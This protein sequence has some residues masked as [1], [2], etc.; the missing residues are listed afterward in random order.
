[1][2]RTFFAL[3]PAD[4]H[5]KAF[6][7]VGLTLLSVILRAL[8]A[9]LLVP[10]IAALFGPDPARAW[11]WVGLLALV[12]AAGWVIDAVIS[13]IGIDLGFALLDN[14]Q[15]GVADR[16]ARIRLSWFTASNTATAREAIASGGPD[17]VGIIVYL[18]TPLLAGITLPVAIALA[19]L[20]ISVPLGIAALIG[21]PILLAAFLGGAR[22]GRRADRAAAESNTEL[23]ERVVEFAHTQQALRAARRSAPARSL[24]GA[25]LARQHGA[26]MK[27]MLLQIPGQLLFGLA[28]QLALLILAG[29]TAYLTVTGRLGV[30]EAIALIVVIT[31]YLEPFTSLA[32]L[33]PAI[34]TT[35]GVLRTIRAVLEAPTTSRGTTSAEFAAPPRIEFQQVSF[36]YGQT[37]E[38]RADGGQ[39]AA[40]VL[41]ELDLSVEPG[42]TTAIIG[43]SGSGKSTILSLVAG[44]QEPSSGRVLID[45]Q[46]PRDWD[47]ETRRRAASVVFQHPYLFEGSIRENILA[48]AMGSPGTTGA[49]DSTTDATHHHLDT[50][51]RLARVDELTTRL[52]GGWEA[53]VGEGGTALSGGERQRVSIARAILKPAPILLV[54]EATSALD[55]ENETAIVT[56]LTEDATPRTRILVAH[57]LE[58]IRTADRVIF[59]ADGGVVEDGSI[60]QLLA[61]NGR[62]A[63]FWSEQDA[64]A[65]WKLGTP[66]PD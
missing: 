56:A 37:E 57:R 59:L 52:P 3:L 29:T 14:A 10:L 60:E 22:I 47:A 17:L 34:E 46:D 40:E 21:V 9:V 6:L 7:H 66:N 25:A 15:H 43:P 19:L 23:T 51:A 16:L 48:G 4:R 24:V 11:P 55:T 44:L 28:S 65:D 18:L 30:A 33:A 39:N 12:T 41:H 35:T 53:E 49:T 42:T 26:T 8:G 5:R 63:H 58:S 54:D 31:R 45:G 1:M 32:E 2:I 27:L 64:A 13:R 61:A 62:F 50:V 36:R 38:G 20:P